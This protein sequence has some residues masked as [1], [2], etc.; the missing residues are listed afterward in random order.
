MRGLAM[1]VMAATL[2]VSG[3]RAEDDLDL[4]KRAVNQAEAKPGAA[5]KPGVATKPAA[6][7]MAKKGEPQWLRVRVTGKGDNKQKVSVNLPLAF[8]RAVGTDWPLSFGSAC[9]HGH[10]AHYCSIK[11]SEVLKSLESGEDIVE[12]DDEQQS[13]RVW[14]E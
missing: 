3:L 5:A 9:H 13:V 10:E 11:L 6:A 1:G 2:V 8:V 14:V 4:I 7:P 12:V